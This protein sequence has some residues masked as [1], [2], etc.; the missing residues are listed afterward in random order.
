M[1]G[2]PPPPPPPPP[3]MPGAGGGPPPPPP[4]PGGGSLPPRPPAGA[5]KGRVRT[6]L[7][8]FAWPPSEVI[9]Y[10][11]EADDFGREHY[12]QTLTKERN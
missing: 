1:N 8:E 10:E 4:M 9:W 7:E 12:C 11:S 5:G 2:P 6:T 3:P